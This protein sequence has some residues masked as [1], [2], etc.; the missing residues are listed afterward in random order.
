MAQCTRGRLS[1][2]T[3]RLAS[4]VRR[5][6]RRRRGQRALPRPHRRCRSPHDGASGDQWIDVHDTRQ[7][8][9]RT[10]DRRCPLRDRSLFLGG[11][12]GRPA[13]PRRA[14]ILAELRL[15]VVS[16]HKTVAEVTLVVLAF[17]VIALG[18]WIRA[19]VAEFRQRVRQAFT[20]SALLRGGS[21]L[22]SP[23]SSPSGR[24]GSRRSGSCSAR[25]ESSSPPRNVLLVQAAG[26]PRDARAHQPRRGRDTTGAPR[27]HAPW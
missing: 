27:L 14:P 25:F 6:R 23:G 26:E 20:V 1:R 12:A 5:V 11:D 10:D 17:A 19:N 3:R 24:F 2:H 13:E 4:S 22:L 16:R 7:L 8:E 18:V 15:R 9:P 21:A